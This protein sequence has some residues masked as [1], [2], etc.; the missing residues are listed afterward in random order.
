MDWIFLKA[1][2]KRLNNTN[3]LLLMTKKF[4]IPTDIE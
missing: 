4:I 3:I 2:G 1:I